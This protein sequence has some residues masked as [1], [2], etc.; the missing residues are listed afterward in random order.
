MPRRWFSDIRFETD[1]FLFKSMYNIKI[2]IISLISVSKWIRF[3][4]GTVFNLFEKHLRNT[5]FGERRNLRPL[6]KIV[7]FENIFIRWLAD[8]KSE[9]RLESIPRAHPSQRSGPIFKNGRTPY[10]YER[11]R[12]QSSEIAP[13]LKRM[14]VN[15]RL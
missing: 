7:H 1:P 4:N 13:S 12:F 8:S 5:K 6:L 3:G 10:T 15:S 11:T 9:I 14:S 2:S